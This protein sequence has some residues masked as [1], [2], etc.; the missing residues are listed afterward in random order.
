MFVVRRIIWDN[1]NVTH[2]ARHGVTPQEVEEIYY[3]KPITNRT[4]KGRILVVGSTRK[5]RVLTVILAPTAEEQVYYVVT[6]RPADR[7]ER[8]NY[9]Q[10]R[11]DRKL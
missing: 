3:G 6:A 10:Q 5:S 1:W 8:R 9:E 7:K 2:I 4:Y 11:K